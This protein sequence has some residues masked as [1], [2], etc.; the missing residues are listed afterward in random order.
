MN[1]GRSQT[2]EDAACSND[3]VLFPGGFSYPVTTP[4]NPRDR[5][6]GTLFAQRADT[7]TPQTICSEFNFSNAHLT[8][9]EYFLFKKFLFHNFSHG[10]TLSNVLQNKRRRD[11][12]GDSR[13]FRN[14]QFGILFNIRAQVDIGSLI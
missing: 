6:C 10:E 9:S 8:W 13:R 12:D 2:T 3:Y 14:R 11:T 5:F 7:D 1:F 4:L